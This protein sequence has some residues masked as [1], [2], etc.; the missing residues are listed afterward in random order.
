MRQTMKIYKSIIAV[1]ATASLFCATSCQEKQSGSDELSGAGFFPAQT[2]SYNL[3]QNPEIKASVVRLGN[4]GDLT[5][6]LSA[7][8]SSKFTLPSSVTIKDGDRMADFDIAYNIS[9]LS[10]NEAYELDVTI[11]NYSS[12]FGYETIK[13]VIEYPTSYYEY[14]KG[15]IAE[16]WWGEQEDKVLYAREFAANVLQ[17]YLPDCW[18]HDS[19]AG[20]PV[21]DY[22]FYWNTETNKLYVPFQFMGCEDWCIADRGAVA[23]KFGGP[24]YKEG[25]SDWMKYIDSFYAS[26]GY[27]QP[28]YDPATKRFYLSDSAACSPATGAVAYGTP[29]SPDIFTME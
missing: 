22:V 5:V 2:M 1:L 27:N 9:E 17:C 24:G 23:C 21:Q 8:G 13:L 29:G 28:H 25:S 16:D 15:T 18:G 19:G 26:K 4:S 14:G 12:L 11:G 10:F 3:T 20:Y 6:N 7:S